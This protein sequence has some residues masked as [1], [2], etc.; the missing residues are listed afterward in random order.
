MCV[1]AVAQKFASSLWQTLHDSYDWV[2]GEIDPVGGQA[3]G[4]GFY[5]WPMAEKLRSQGD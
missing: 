1:A 2:H 4:P 5:N 3:V